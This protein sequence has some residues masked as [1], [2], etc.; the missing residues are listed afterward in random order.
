MNVTGTTN[1]GR[2]LYNFINQSILLESKKSCTTVTSKNF[3][4]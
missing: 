3:D 1:G 2:S 4:T